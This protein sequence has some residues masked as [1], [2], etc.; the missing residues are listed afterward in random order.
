MDT[1]MVEVTATTA[2]ISI[3]IATAIGIFS[4]W[5]VTSVCYSL[6]SDNHAQDR[7]NQGFKEGIESGSRTTA[8][9]IRAKLVQRLADVADEIEAEEL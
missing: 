8:S 4:G 6:K 7:Y 9:K 1:L 3:T 5:L 2:L